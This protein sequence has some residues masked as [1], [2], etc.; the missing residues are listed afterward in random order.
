MALL[1]DSLKRQVA[2]VEDACLKKGNA[3]KGDAQTCAFVLGNRCVLWPFAAYAVSFAVILQ[4]I[5]L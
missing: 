4:T 3:E 2:H 1:I 5:C